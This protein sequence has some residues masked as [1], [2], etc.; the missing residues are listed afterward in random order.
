VGF[1]PPDSES[2]FPRSSKILVE[3]PS[4]AADDSGLFLRD[5]AMRPSTAFA[6]GD[7]R[8]VG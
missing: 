5:C 1:G 7:R 3:I 6:R 8:L 2:T 4:G